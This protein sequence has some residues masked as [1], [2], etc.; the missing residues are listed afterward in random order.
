MHL[1]SEWSEGRRREEQEAAKNEQLISTTN[2]RQSSSYTMTNKRPSQRSSHSNK[3]HYITLSV[4]ILT[5]L[6]SIVN[7][8]VQH[9][10]NHEPAEKNMMSAKNNLNNYRHANK[11]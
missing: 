11:V 6:F 8:S 3:A 10:N 9:L 5:Y 2:K 1:K 7:C 4:L